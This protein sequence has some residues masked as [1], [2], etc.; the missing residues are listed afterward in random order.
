MLVTYSIAWLANY[1]ENKKL[2]FNF[3]KIWQD[4]KIGDNIENIFM[5]IIPSIY[6]K[7]NAD[8]ERTLPQQAK[9]RG[10]WDRLKVAMFPLDKEL[11]D[12]ITIGKEE[13]TMLHAQGQNQQQPLTLN[14][15]W[16][17]LRW[18]PW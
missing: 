7:M 15:K 2:Y 5:S 6:Q 1:L 10:T 17:W 4:Q 11:I 18:R 3:E 8:A 14:P 12:S 16:T 13:A 9:T